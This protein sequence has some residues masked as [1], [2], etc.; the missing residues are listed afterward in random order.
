MTW[1]RVLGS[2]LG[3]LFR[4]GRIDGELEAEMRSHLDSLADEN[5]RR[6]MNPEEAQRA[7]NAQFADRA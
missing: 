6:G 7:A 4:K 3:G 2:R 5:L 1:L